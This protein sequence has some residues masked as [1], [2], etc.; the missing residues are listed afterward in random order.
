MA[1][2]HDETPTDPVP[3]VA[4][5]P[6]AAATPWFDDVAAES[7]LI[8]DHVTGADGSYF[9][10]EISA[11]GCVLFDYD[12]DGDL[13]AYL[14]QS[15]P[16]SDLPGPEIAPT[17]STG[18][19]N[20]LFRND[21]TVDADGVRTLRFVDVTD[22][23]GVGDRGYGMGAAVGD[24][25]NDGDLDLFVANVGPN[26]LYRNNG[27]GTF[28]DISD[29]V[30]PE[31]RWSTSASFADYDGDGHADLY[32][33][34]YVNFSLGDNKICHSS[35][36][37][38]DY[39]GPQ[40]Y[41]A[42]TD[43]LY[44]NVDGERFEDVTSAAGVDTAA[45]SGLGVVA[46]DAN[47]DD[48]LD[49]YVANDG[50]A[51]LLW[52]NQGDGTFIDDGLLSGSAYNAEGAAEAGMGVVAEDFDDDGDDDI[53]LSHLLGESNT[54]LVNDGRGGFDD[55]T[56]R[57]GLAAASRPY[58]GFG[59]D[60]FDLEGDGDL[61]LFVANGGVILEAQ[62]LDADRPYAQRNQLFLSSGPPAYRFTD[63]SDRGPGAGLA[64]QVSRGAAFGD[65]DND[66]DV[67]ILV[68]NADGPTRLYLNRAG[69]DA[70]WLRLRLVG[71]SHRRDAQG[72]VVF[73]EQD[74]GTLRRRVRSDGGYAAGH[75]FRVRFGLGADADAT[76]VVRVAWPG[77]RIERFDG[78]APDRDLVLR[79]GEGT[80]VD[81]RAD[82]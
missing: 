9:F 4:P 46:F 7:G 42:I 29:R 58:T 45:G 54:L 12:N 21:L 65:V 26:T 16:L 41:T 36:G 8:D 53:F 38:R 20:R 1:G 35:G 17:P 33:A 67:D 18:G 30:P 70:S 63:A 28:A 55:A 73:L 6:A 56:N 2:C 49:F 78:L 80:S 75:D 25:D 52:I 72:A 60:W 66:G 43:R 32:V 69:D 27:D 40:S 44:R 37:R 47:G 51:N 5:D 23:A 50:D 24:I 14:L 3:S 62:P 39:C 76:Y 15:F 31:P 34:N 64:P 81:G 57:F 11:A 77:G 74:G 10:P 13:D 82:E 71:S 22:A 68:R 59:V 19:A 61:D 48:Q 79:E